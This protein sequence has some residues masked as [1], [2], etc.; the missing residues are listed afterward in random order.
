MAQTELEIT[1]MICL[2]WCKERVCRNK[3]GWNKPCQWLPFQTGRIVI[4]GQV[5]LKCYFHRIVMSIF[6]CYCCRRR[7]F[8][9]IST[10]G[11]FK[12]N[13]P[14]SATVSE[15]K[16]AK[17]RGLLSENRILVILVDVADQGKFPGDL[18]IQ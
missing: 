12:I 9:Y 17:E 13:Q 3:A 18:L 8:A 6:A 10:R 1:E 5:S 11:T 14:C 15:D 2:L 16:L 7:R 4:D